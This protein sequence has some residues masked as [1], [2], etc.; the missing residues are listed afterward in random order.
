MAVYVTVRS[1]LHC[2]TTDARHR[3]DTPD[4]GEPLAQPF[5]SLESNLAAARVYAINAN[6]PLVFASVGNVRFL[7]A[8][9]VDLAVVEAA[10]STVEQPL[11]YH[12]F[13]TKGLAETAPYDSD[14]EQSWGILQQIVKSFPAYIPKVEGGFVVR[15][16]NPIA[17]MLAGLR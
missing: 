14:S 8:Q 10:V 4:A 5:E 2:H 6:A 9:G 15:R 12:S 3:T 16:L 1:L 13:E 11:V 17:E 7:D